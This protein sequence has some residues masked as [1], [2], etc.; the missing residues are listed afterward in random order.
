MPIQRIEQEIQAAVLGVE[1]AA[2]HRAKLT[3][4]H[5]RPPVETDPSPHWLDAIDRLYQALDRNAEGGSPR[6]PDSDDSVRS[7][8]RQLLR[9]NVSEALWNRVEMHLECRVGAFADHVARF[10]DER[11]VDLL[12]MSSVPTR[13]WLPILPA[14]KRQVLR[15]ASPQVILVGPGAAR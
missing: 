3:V 13:W 7:G 10:A 5:V 11:I 12:I 9:R 4:L 15:R 8:I 2:L 6:A 1:M 14:P